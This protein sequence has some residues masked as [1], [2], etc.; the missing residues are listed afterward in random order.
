MANVIETP[1]VTSEDIRDLVLKASGCTSMKD[2]FALIRNKRVMEKTRFM[3][4]FYFCNEDEHDGVVGIFVGHFLYMLC[5]VPITYHRSIDHAIVIEE[6]V[7]GH[8]SN[9]VPL[10]N[11]TADIKLHEIEAALTKLFSNG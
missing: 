5:I 7:P 10:K 9:F 2:V 4:G 3:S 1:S 6:H 8:L 11:T